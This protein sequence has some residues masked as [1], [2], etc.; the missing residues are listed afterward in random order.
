MADFYARYLDKIKSFSYGQLLLAI[1]NDPML[2]YEDE[3][4]E[5]M[6][7]LSRRLRGWVESTDEESKGH[8]KRS[9][10]HKALLILHLCPWLIRSKEFSWLFQDI[11][12]L[13]RKSHYSS[14][15]FKEYWE[16]LQT[17]KGKFRTTKANEPELP[18]KVFG[19]VI[20]QIKV[21]TDKLQHQKRTRVVE[22]LKALYEHHDDFDYYSN[23][24]QKLP[25]S[26]EVI[27]EELRRL[28]ELIERHSKNEQIPPIEFIKK[29]H[30]VIVNEIYMD[31]ISNK[32]FWN[33]VFERKQFLKEEKEIL[34]QTKK[35]VL[36]T[37]KDERGKQKR[38]M[39]ERTMQRYL[40]Y[41]NDLW[42][43][44]EVYS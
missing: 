35:E 17:V 20:E 25:F 5:K 23:L 26:L 13:I 24:P 42:K 19:A 22:V 21:R 28:S 31:K 38:K 43:K 30:Q 7:E 41:I 27:Y 11:C 9:K 36:R 14:I 12:A 2:I 40:K 6:E 15:A 10:A 32:K 39:S 37:H 16:A 29:N 4:K 44:S 3:L 18:F 8:K 1:H 33:Y 34:P